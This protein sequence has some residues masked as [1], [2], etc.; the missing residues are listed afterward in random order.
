MLKVSYAYILKAYEMLE[1][2]FLFFIQGISGIESY[3]L[4]H[5]CIRINSRYL[6]IFSTNYVA[7][8]P[9]YSRHFQIY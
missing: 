1:E 4:A 5:H 7:L 9:Y 8:A 6:I 2:D 3:T